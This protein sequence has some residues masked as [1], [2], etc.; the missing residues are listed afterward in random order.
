MSRGLRSGAGTCTGRWSCPPS[1]AMPLQLS[2]SSA[3]SLLDPALVAK[4]SDSEGTLEQE[5]N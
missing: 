4:V 3:K 2:L 1:C 5:H